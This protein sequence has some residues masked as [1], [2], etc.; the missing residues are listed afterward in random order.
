M[1]TVLDHSPMM[2]YKRA[3]TFDDASSSIWFR[4]NVASID[5]RVDDTGALTVINVDNWA[6][7]TLR[8]YADA[9]PI[10]GAG[11]RR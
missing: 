8:P 3:W 6:I 1:V 2:I 9:V 7:T 5:C 4:H 11:S 10:D